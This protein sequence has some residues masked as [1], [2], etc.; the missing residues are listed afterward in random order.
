MLFRSIV[1]GLAPALQATHISLAQN[2]K[3]GSGTSEGVSRHRVKCALVAGQVALS[4]TLLVGA[5]LFIRTLRNLGHA[6]IGF[7]RG[8]IAIFDVDPT[9]FGYHGERLRLFYD[10]MV[11]RARATPGVK[12]AAISS[13]TPFGTWM[14]SSTFSAEGYQPKPGETPVAIVNSVS[15]GYFRTLGASILLGRDFRPLD[16]PVVTPGESLLSAMGRASGGTNESRA[17]AAHICIIDDAM[18][19]HLFGDANPLGR[20]LSFEDKYTPG[21]TLEIVGVVKNIHYHSVRSAEELGAIYQPSWSDGPGVRSLEIRFT[22]SLAPVVAGIRA[23]LH[24]MNPNVPVLRRADNGR[25][26][27]RCRGA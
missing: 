7:D 1:F 17:S 11:D 8:N 23:A 27:K 4:L 24:D 10:Q 22:G 14:S 26:C 6:N 3:Q 12:V 13:M 15:S 25:V 18:S 20:H 19:Y 9:N 21:K 16:E 5:N 2:I